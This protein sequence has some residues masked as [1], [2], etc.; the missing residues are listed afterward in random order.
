[1]ILN[2]QETFEEAKSAKKNSDKVRILAFGSSNTDRRIVGMHWLDCL[3]LAL[4]EKHGRIHHC[5]RETP[6]TD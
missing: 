5:V 4:K 3:D 1:M 2:I 6:E